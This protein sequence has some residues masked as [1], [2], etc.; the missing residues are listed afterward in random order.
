M[1]DNIIQRIIKMVLDKESAKKTQDDANQMASKIDDTWKS[2]AQKIGG[3]LAAGFLI[4]NV[5]GCGKAAIAEATSSEKA[6]KQLKGTSD[7]TGAEYDAM[8]DKMV[9]AVK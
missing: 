6:C 2:V 3:Y 1:A 8:Q 7:N 4:S 5:F 9:A